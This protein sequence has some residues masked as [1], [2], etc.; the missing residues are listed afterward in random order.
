MQYELWARSR[1]TK[2]YEFIKAFQDKNQSYCLLDQ[3]DPNFYCEAIILLTEWQ[4]QPKCVM[5][6]ELKAKVKTLQ[7]F[8]D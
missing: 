5:F 3:V 8:K 4:Q 6:R 7:R 1:E 2:V